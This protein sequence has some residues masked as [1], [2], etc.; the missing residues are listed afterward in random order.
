VESL[1]VREII[2]ND[3]VSYSREGEY[4]LRYYALNLH[5]TQAILIRVYNEMIF[6]SLQ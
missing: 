6:Q 2:E 1:L 3:P 5:Y 4:E